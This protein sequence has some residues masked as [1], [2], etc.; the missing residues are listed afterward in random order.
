MPAESTTTGGNSSIWMRTGIRWARRTHCE[1]RIDVGDPLSGG[2]RVRNVD[3]AS[4]ARDVTVQGLAVA[5]QLDARRITRA[6]RSQVRFLEI[7]I[8][9]K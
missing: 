7:V 3:G 6:D 9:Q 5:H 1:D 4:D 2:L 8:N